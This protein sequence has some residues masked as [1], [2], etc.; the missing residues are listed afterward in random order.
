MSQAPATSSSILNCA[1]CVTTFT[2]RQ[3]EKFPLNTFFSLQTFRFY[4]S[5]VDYFGSILE[6]PLSILQLYQINNLGHS[7]EFYQTDKAKS[8]TQ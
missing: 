5:T 3:A 8:K 7:E 1:T 4:H 6:Y 2:E